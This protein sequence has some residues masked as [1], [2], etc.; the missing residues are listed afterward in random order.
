MHVSSGVRTQMYWYNVRIYVK[1][2]TS[3]KI[4]YNHIHA[5]LERQRGLVV[6]EIAREIVISGVHA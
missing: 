6:H 1:K 3:S 2:S 5:L 4:Q